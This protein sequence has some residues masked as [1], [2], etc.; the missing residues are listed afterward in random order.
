MGRINLSRVFLGGMAAGATAIVL[1]YIAFSAG[2][3]AALS[4]L[5]GINMHEFPASTHIF[6]AAVQLLVGGPLAVWLYAAIRPRF[7]AG[8]RTAVITGTYIWA[9]LCLYGLSVLT[10]LGLL[11]KLPLGVSIMMLVMDLPFVIVCTM[12]GAKIY[13]EE[14]TGAAHS[15]AAGD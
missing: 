5:T 7:G 10:V 13:Q 14:G 6:M 3:Y 15:A 1:E 4:R 9:A 11:P 8:P 12:V 2:A